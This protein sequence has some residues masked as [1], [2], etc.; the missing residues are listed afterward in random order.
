[1]SP[2]LTITNIAMM[3]ITNMNMNIRFNMGKDTGTLIPI[4]RRRI[5]TPTSPMRI[6][7]MAIE[8]AA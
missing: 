8:I 6:I 2:W 4:C 7:D 3:N 1:M 5:L